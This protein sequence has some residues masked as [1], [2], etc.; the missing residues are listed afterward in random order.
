[1]GKSLSA[2]KPIMENNLKSDFSPLFKAAFFEALKAQAKCIEDDTKSA[3]NK[4]KSGGDPT[5]DDE[6]ALK[7]AAEKFTEEL[8]ADLA[9]IIATEVHNYVKEIMITINNAPILPTVV[10]PMGPCTGTLTIPPTSF[11]IS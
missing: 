11:Q 1:M 4:S 8:S 10:S 2:A 6:K 3:V 9:K 5:K 7:K